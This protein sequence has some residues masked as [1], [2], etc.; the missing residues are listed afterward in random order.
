[1]I[2]VTIP[3]GPEPVYLQ[4]LQECVQSVIDQTHPVDEILIIDDQAHLWATDLFRSLWQSHPNVRLW[5]T[6]W[7]SG[8]AHSFNFGVAKATNDLV[9]MLGSDDTLKPWAVGDCLR[10][11]DKHQ[12]PLG[13]YWMDV[14]YSH[15]ETQ[16]LPCNAAMV[17]KKLWAN[18]GGFPV[19]S[20]IGA[21][22][23]V[24][25][26]VMA[27]HPDAGH[28][29]KVESDAPP[30]WYRAH[31]QTYS[32]RIGSKLAGAS[33]IVRDYYT[34]NWEKPTWPKK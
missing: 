24:I 34:A 21:M 18:L 19:Q 2:T 10:A 9:I 33:A 3:V 26:S 13:Y 5:D 28:M 8:V 27:T 32:R 15:G 1:M 12:D 16:S 31:D 17:H 22:D 4:Y 6:P 11:W 7:L 29:I 14:E 23:T 20:A 25:M 30:Y